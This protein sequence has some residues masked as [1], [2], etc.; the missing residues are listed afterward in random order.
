MRAEEED[1]RP[2]FRKSGGVSGSSLVLRSLK[3]LNLFA[4]RGGGGGIYDLE[5]LLRLG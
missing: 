4:L 2:P 1:C 5:A 3:H